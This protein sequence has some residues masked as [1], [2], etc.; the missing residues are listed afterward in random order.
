[1]QLV[2]YLNFER[3]CREAFEFYQR[4]LGGELVA[5]ITHGEMGIPGDEETRA[6][7]LHAR[8]VI[9]DQTLMGS[10]VSS[11]VNGIP[12]PI[13]ISVQL[14][15]ISEAE[16]IFSALAEGGNVVMPIEEQPWAIRFGMFTD[17]FDVPWMINCE[18]ES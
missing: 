18:Q 15:S 1:M 8:L 6:Q 14:D 13:Q 17:R 5:M 4:V 11:E 2:A 9:G 12:A 3:K 16:R 7:I 10:D